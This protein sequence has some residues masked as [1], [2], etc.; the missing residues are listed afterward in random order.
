M[1]TIL[2]ISKA[3]PQ[4]WN[5]LA[6]SSVLQVP[7]SMLRNPKSQ[8]LGTPKALGIDRAF[9]VPLIAS[10]TRPAGACSATQLRVA[11]WSPEVRVRLS[12][13]KVRVLILSARNLVA[14]QVSSDGLLFVGCSADGRMHPDTSPPSHPFQSRDVCEIM[15]D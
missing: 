14:V 2:P 8:L 5:V 9:L 12:I 7:G 13:R 6:C 11:Y 4:S 1:C 3:I 15:T 10:I